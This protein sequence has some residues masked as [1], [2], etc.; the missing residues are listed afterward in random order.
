MELEKL[1]LEKFR[2]GE[3]VEVLA[4]PPEHHEAAFLHTW[5]LARLLAWAIL[6]QRPGKRPPKGARPNSDEPKKRKIRTAN[7]KQAGQITLACLLDR[8]LSRGQKGSEEYKT[9]FG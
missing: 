5:A 1:E 6:D 3:A 2:P 4:G 8:H 9:N 7:A